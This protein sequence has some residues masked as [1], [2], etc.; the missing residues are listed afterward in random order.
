MALGG[1]GP[2]HIT[3]GVHGAATTQETIIRAGLSGGASVS[4]VEILDSK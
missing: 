2:S 4:C 1:I 3:E